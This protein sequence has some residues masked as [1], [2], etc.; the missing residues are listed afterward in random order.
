MGMQIKEETKLY[1]VRSGYCVF[2]GN[3]RIKE[4][5]VE[6]TDAQY[7]DQPHKVELV[8]EKE[9]FTIPVLTPGISDNKE[10]EESNI[11][12][13]VKKPAFTRVIKTPKKTG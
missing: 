5:S 6:L 9:E 13:S 2:K 12:R 11:D 1:K 10:T 4:G 3:L 8:E 7:K